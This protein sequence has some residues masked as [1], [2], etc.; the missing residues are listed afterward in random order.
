MSSRLA[1]I[2]G[3]RKRCSGLSANFAAHYIGVTAGDVNQFKEAG[4]AVILH[5][6]ESKSGN[7]KEP[8]P[9]ART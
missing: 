9:S 2:P 3:H 4:R 7:L 8:Y 1:R 6:N 5:P